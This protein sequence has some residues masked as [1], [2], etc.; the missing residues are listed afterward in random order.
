MHEEFK[1]IM[2]F[3]SLS[4]EEKVK[5]LDD[6]FHN[7]IEFFE[8]F[9][10]TLHSGTPE[11]KSAFMKEVM[12]LQ[13]KL[14]LETEKMCKETGLSED[15]LKE[16]SQQKENFSE[17]EWRSIQSAKQKFEEQAEELTSIIPQ[18]Q[19]PQESSKKEGKKTVKKKWVKS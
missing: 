12:E 9:K 13:E 6:V 16:F 7:S 5:H 17:E 11:E 8:H 10:K 18:P 1:K 3:F 14:K 2:S 15:E 4:P 19:K